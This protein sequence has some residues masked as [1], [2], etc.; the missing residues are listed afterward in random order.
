VLGGQ[1]A[2]LRLRHLDQ[3]LEYAVVQVGEKSIR[4]CTTNENCKF[5]IELNNSSGQGQ[6][7]MAQVL[8]KQ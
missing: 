5:K 7:G 4:K 1:L 3:R 2:V 8:K 6:K